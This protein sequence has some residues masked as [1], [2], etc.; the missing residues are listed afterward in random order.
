[1]MIAT[2][3]TSGNNLSAVA[4][5]GGGVLPPAGEEIREGLENVLGFFRTLHGWASNAGKATVVGDELANGG[6]RIA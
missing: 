6:S 2:G 1:M 3:K 5:V 4:S